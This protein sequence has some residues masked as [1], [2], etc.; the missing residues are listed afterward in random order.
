M[1][2]KARI[3]QVLAVAGVLAALLSFRLPAQAEDIDLFTLNP[4]LSDQRPN[5]L[6]MLDSSANWD[7][8]D[9]IAGDK[10]SKHVLNAMATTIESLTDQFNVGLMMWA[11][12][13]GGDNNVDGGVMRMGMRWMNADNRA[14]LAAFFRSVNSGFDKSN[15][16]SAGLGF[17]EA[18]YYYSGLRAVASLAKQKR[19]YL[20]NNWASFSG[21]QLKAPQAMQDA[22]TAIWNLPLPA[23]TP[24]PRNALTNSFSTDYNTPVTDACQKNFIIFLANGPFSDNNASNTNATSRLSAAGGNTNTI[25]FTE[26]TGLQGNISDEWARFLSN[27]DPNN[28]SKP[29]VITYAV[30]VN[31]GTTGQQP[32]TTQLLKSIATEGKGKYFGV[33]SAGGGVEIADALTKIFAEIAA[34]NSVFASSTLPVSVNVR[35]AFLNQVYMGVFRPDA[36]SSPRWPGNVKHFAL[37]DN[38]QGD[39]FLVDKNNNPIEN[40][41][42]GF[43]SP[44]AVSYWTTPSTFWNNV[45]YPDTV[46]K[47]PQAATTSDSPDGEFVEKGGAAQ[48]LR[49]VYA[50]TINDASTGR[51]LYTCVGC[52]TG[53]DLSSSTSHAFSTANSNI[54]DALMGISVPK[55]VTSLT[56][57]GNTVTATA[58]GHGFI[59][60]QSVTMSGADQPDYNVTANVTVVNANSFTYSITE[61]PV[62]PATVQEGQTLTAARGG[63]PQDVDSITLAGTT[64]TVTTPAAHGFAT[65]NSVKIDGATQPEYNGVFTIVRLNDTQ[66]T[67]TVTT[68]PRQPTVMGSVVVTR[69]NGTTAG[70]PI[71][72]MTRVGTTVA[73]ATSSN[74]LSG[75]VTCASVTITGALPTDYDVAGRAC[76]KTGTKSF[77][78]ELDASQLTPSSPATGSIS[79]ASAQSFAVASITRT[80]GSGTVTVTTN[81]AHNFNNNDPVTI[82]GAVQTTYNGTFQISNSNQAGRTFTYTVVPLP[83]TPATG[84]ITATG[85]SGLQ[86]ADVIN[87]VRGENVQEDD[88]PSNDPTRATYVRGYLHGDVLHS[89]PAVINYNR[90]GQPEDR[91]LVV[92]YGGNDGIIHA[93]KGGQDDSDG[94]EKWGFVPT[95]FF[96]GFARLYT[97]TPIISP[98]NTRTYFAD[99]PI[100]VDAVYITDASDPPQER[101]EGVGARAQIY[102]G[103]RRGGRVYYSLD[104]TN[105]DAPAYKW[106]IS[107]ETAG[108]SELGQ[109]WSEARVAKLRLATCPGGHEAG[110]GSICKV[111]VFGAGYDR[112]ANDPETQGTAT[113]GR[114][115]FVVDAKTGERIWHTGPS[116]SSPGAGHYVQSANMLFA[117][118][119]DLSVINTDLDVQGLAD[120]IYAADTGGNIWR[121]N[122]SDSNP[123]NWKVYQ[124]ARLRTSGAANARK[125]LFAPDVVQFDT[126]TDSILIGSGDREHPHDTTILNRYYMIKDPHPLNYFPELSG[127][128]GVQDPN[129]IVTEDM[130]CNLTG[131]P[132]QGSDAAAATFARDCLADTTKKGWRLELVGPDPLDPTNASKFSPGEK[133]VTG[134]TTLGG[135]VIFATNTPKQA[136]LAPGQCTGSLGTALIYAISF[137]DATATIDFDGSGTVGQSEQ[138]T[139]RV[140]GGF[141]PTAIPFATKIGNKWYEGAITGTKVVQPPTSPIGQRYRVF[142][143]LSV[144]N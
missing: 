52:A 116:A 132:I 86:K 21:D 138:F 80:V 117:I 66:F 103:M 133:T 46:A 112:A 40:A 36:N 122:I 88:N 50:T 41:V 121:V 82:S 25:L 27:P 33:S 61:R 20:G 17:A 70:S 95:E 78:F 106:K 119:A 26:N 5:V 141:P 93:V 101:L 47:P 16:T 24:L 77:T 90:V 7:Q 59:A 96:T 142:W 123:A 62:S 29:I 143:N 12:T 28:I 4:D 136:V 30:E 92:Y 91:D 64:A 94:F 125:F 97:E 56:R 1:I 42:T 14:S 38:A 108:F 9:Q 89:R 72:S 11:E 81:T 3:F 73:V 37:A 110:G 111:L 131:N 113:M 49:G 124:V 55:A 39:V 48:R 31:P 19:D 18:Y 74:V 120:R 57:S 71:S 100:S 13:G 8:N 102:I 44:S 23:G 104:V 34:V 45:Y 144:D 84:T 128:P 15:N 2:G 107:N 58:A 63:A 130:L 137:R 85:S 51:R 22:S 83:I 126:S 118:P 60:G 67:Y 35:G 79:V 53:T 75:N 105:P 87:W 134:A 65:N 76:T 6:I 135:T 43:I 69:N 54:T 32:N 129:S 114:G 140:G 98:N 10:R 68:G 115:I 127:S 109:T 139:Q 99:G